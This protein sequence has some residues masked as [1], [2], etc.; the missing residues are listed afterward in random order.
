MQKGG[1]S[2]DMKR[3]MIGGHWMM[4]RTRVTSLDVNFG[5]DNRR[6]GG[7]WWCW[8]MGYVASRSGT[9]TT[10]VMDE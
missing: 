1:Q 2:G 8:W 5:H 3:V 10:T 9:T 4:G 6:T 7:W